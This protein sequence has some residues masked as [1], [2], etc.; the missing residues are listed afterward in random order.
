M[1]GYGATHSGCGKEFGARPFGWTWKPH[2]VTCEACR[3][4]LSDG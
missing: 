1:A 2:D 3:E 4:K